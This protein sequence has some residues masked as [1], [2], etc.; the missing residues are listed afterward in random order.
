MS[1]DLVLHRRRNHADALFHLGEQHALA[2]AKQN[3]GII[4][5]Q[6]EH[7]AGD[8]LDE[9]RFTRSVRTEHGNVFSLMQ[10]ERIN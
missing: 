6:R 3:R 10:Y 2:A 8:E 4:S 5:M 7:L 1:R 9:R